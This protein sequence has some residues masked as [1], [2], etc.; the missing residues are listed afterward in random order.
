MEVVD[1]FLV[2]NPANAEARVWKKR[3]RAAQE[4]EAALK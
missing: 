2:I 3:I 1:Q 4:A